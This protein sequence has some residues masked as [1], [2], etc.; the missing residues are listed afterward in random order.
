MTYIVRYYDAIGHV[1]K[2]E[3]H[4]PGA[5]TERWYALVAAG[6]PSVKLTTNK[7]RA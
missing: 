3:F 5:A 6:Y 4:S 7:Q 2:E 1:V